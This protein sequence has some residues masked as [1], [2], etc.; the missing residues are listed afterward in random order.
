MAEGQVV[1][2]AQGGGEVG[3][4]PLG[5][6]LEGSLVLGVQ[7]DGEG[8]VEEP[9]PPPLHLVAQAGDVLQGDLRL[10][11]HGAPALEGEGLG[12]L[13]AHL[14]PLKRPR[15][16]LGGNRADV[17]GQVHRCSGGHQPL[18]EAGSKGPG[19]LAQVEGAH[20]GPAYAHGAAANRHLG[21]T[22]LVE[23]CGGSAQGG[24]YE[25]H[26]ELPPL[27][28]VDRQPGPSQQ[29]PQVVD[30]PELAHG[31]EAP[32]EDAVAGLKVSEQT[33]EGLGG[34]P[35]LRGQVRRLRPL[36]VVSQS[37]QAG[38]VLPYEQLRREVQGVEGAGEGPQLRLVQ[39]QAHHLAHP[40]LHPVQAHGTVLVQVRQH[41]EEGQLGRELGRGLRRSTGC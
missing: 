26:A 17:D 6:F 35:R 29:A 38:R 20:E 18:E 21:G 8:R 23:L 33:P 4:G 10:R 31:V 9:L 37:S 12:R 24:C 39:L 1:E 34:G 7:G 32:V 15:R 30:A 36:K 11:G 22:L 2:L 40:Q 14:L 3:L 25:K 28:P 19:P 27:E 16:L 5:H 41:E 13:E